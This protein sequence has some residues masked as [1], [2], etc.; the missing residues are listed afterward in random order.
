MHE[1]E[2]E[3]L[4]TVE[5]LNQDHFQEL[6]EKDEYQ[7]RMEQEFND[8]TLEQEQTHLDKIKDLQTQF[9]ATLD[10]RDAEHQAE[11]R[12]LDQ[13]KTQREQDYIR[14]TRD[15]QSQHAAEIEKLLKDAAD[16]L[17][18]TIDAHTEELNK[19]RMQ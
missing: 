14:K 2:N 5:Q 6:A 18:R 10:A 13:E 17:K 4:K 16:K 1:R 19:F 15:L 3:H 7:K 12:E 8:L 11:L 9:T